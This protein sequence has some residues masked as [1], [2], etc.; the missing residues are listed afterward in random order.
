MSIQNNP[1]L[2]NKRM[3]APD[4]ATA[5]QHLATVAHRTERDGEWCAE[6]INAWE[7]NQTRAA[8]AVVR[9]LLPT[10]ESAF[11]VA[12]RSHAD[13]MRAELAEIEAT[14]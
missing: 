13:E 1:E 5:L 3:S 11:V 8:F 7:R 14:L 2:E 6:V 12:T 10:I 4:L 9:E